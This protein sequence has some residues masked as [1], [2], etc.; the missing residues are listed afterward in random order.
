MITDQTETI[1]D[2]QLMS[3][4]T[5]NLRF[6]K[7]VIEYAQKHNATYIDSVIAVCEKYGLEPQ[8]GAKFLNKFIIEKIKAEGMALH[9][10]PQKTKLPV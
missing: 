2:Q 3:V 10:L 1:L 9:L 4:H 7:D 8:V 5:S 6:P